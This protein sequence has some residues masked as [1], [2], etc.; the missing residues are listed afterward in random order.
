MLD[1]NLVRVRHSK[2]RPCSKALLFLPV[3]S[4]SCLS[5]PSS[6]FVTSVP[7]FAQGKSVLSARNPGVTRAQTWIPRMNLF[8]DISGA[9]RGGASSST[10]PAADVELFPSSFHDAAPSWATLEEQVKSTPT[11]KKML[12]ELAAREKGE[13]PAHTKNSVRLFGKSEK[14]IRI[15]L[16]RD[17][18]AWCPYCQKVWLMLE[19]KQVPYKIER[20]N[21]RSYGDKPDWFMKKVPR[22]LLP[23]V[24]IDGKIVTESVVIMQMIDGLYPEQN[25]ML[26]RDKEGLQRANRVMQLERDLFGAW[27]SYTFQPGTSGKRGFEATLDEVDSALAATDGPWFLGGAGPSLVDMQYISHV[28]R[29][30]PSVLYWKG[31]QMRGTGRW[32]N[33]DRWLAAF[34]ERK[35]YLATKSDY[36]THVMDIPPQYGPGQSVPDSEPF[37][38]KIDGREGWTLPLPPLTEESLEPVLPSWNPGEEAARHEAALSIVS[39]RDAVVRFASRAAGDDV[40]RWQREGGFGRSVLADPYAKPEEALIPDTDACLRIVT[41]ALMHGTDEAA[42][43]MNKDGLGHAAAQKTCLQYLQK[44]VGVPRDMSYP[45]ARQLRAHLGWLMEQI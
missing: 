20:I 32:P 16:Y 42:K 43:V 36:Y 28:E 26:P 22:G 25:P 27:C 39:N 4:F 38:K 41:H 31:L 33:V 3:L 13:G 29:M 23:V 6:A 7:L 35:N 12:E 15:V 8:K 37:Q 19:E 44:R 18:A 11:A 40:G 34:E 24:E 5:A 17:A 30:V 2:L 21:M 10:M 9:L 14:D 1:A 45:A